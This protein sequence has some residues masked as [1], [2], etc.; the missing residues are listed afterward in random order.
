MIFTPEKNLYSKYGNPN[1]VAEFRVFSFNN[2]GAG[3]RHC[4]YLKSNNNFQDF[5][6]VSRLA[7]E[8]KDKNY[9][10]ESCYLLPTDVFENEFNFEILESTGFKEAISYFNYL[11]LATTLRNGFNQNFLDRILKFNSNNLKIEMHVNLRE[12]MIEDQ[13]YLVKLENH[14]SKLKK[15]YGDKI[16]INLALNLGSVFTDSEYQKL[17]ELV[18]NHSDDKILEMNFTF[19]FNPKISKSEKV[20]MMEESY[21]TMQ[22][23]T[24]EFKKVESEYNQRTLLRKPSF[25][26][27]DNSIFLSPIIPFDEYVFLDDEF[28]KLKGPTFDAFLEAYSQMELRN[29]PIL[30]QCGRCE[31]LDVCMGKNFFSLAQTL[32]LPCPKG[33]RD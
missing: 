17:K 19:M 31:Y 5:D 15:I 10:L 27:K 7:A 3:C 32:N 22:F 33:R 16:I 24:G 1:R 4:Y 11:G 9:T 26:F 23:F 2:C 13:S 28:C 29:M 25:T 8:L 21:Q 12:D 6:S 30:N 20:R 18:F 14:I